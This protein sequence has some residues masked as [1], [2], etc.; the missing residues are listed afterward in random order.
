MLTKVRV[1]ANVKKKLNQ[2]WYIGKEDFIQD[3]CNRRERLNSIPL[4]GKK[5]MERFLNA[6]VKN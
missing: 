2:I 4:G 6:M 5:K 3:Y 1:M